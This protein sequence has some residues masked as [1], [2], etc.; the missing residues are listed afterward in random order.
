[1]PKL[2]EWLESYLNEMVNRKMV[3]FIET[4]NDSVYLFGGEKCRAQFSFTKSINSRN[5][6][7]LTFT[8]LSDESS[9]II[10]DEDFF[11]APP[12]TG[13]VCEP[14]TINLDGTDILIADSGSIVTINLE[15]TDEVQVIPDDVQVVGNNIKLVFPVAAPPAY[16]LDLVDRFGNAFP[17]KQVSANAT[18]DLR[19]LTPFDW[20]DIYLNTLTTPPSSLFEDAIIDL[21]DD[22]D[23][24]GLWGLK[25]CIWVLCEGTSFGTAL[26]LRY[27][28]ANKNSF[29]LSHI[30]SPTF[31][32]DGIQYNTTT[33]NSITFYNPE[34]GGIN[35]QHATI[36]S[37]TDSLLSVAAVDMGF[38]GPFT[39]IFIRD[40]NTN[41]SGYQLN[42][43]TNVGGSN[44]NSQ[45]NY[46]INLLSGTGKLVK[47]GSTT[48]ASG[49]VS[50]AENYGI[51]NIN[52]RDNQ[53]RTGRKYS[54]ASVGLGLTDTQIA[55]EYV[56][57]QTFHT[58]LGIQK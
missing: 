20:A 42:G 8:T 13:L 44:T 58:T 37:Q 25:R 18:W 43:S 4:F 29:Q 55:D 32:S 48:I 3:I 17:T 21:V 6:Y 36:Y 38:S 51:F 30:G 9:L 46:L 31:A 57:I 5:G 40:N 50:N 34:Y 56:A 28:F 23:A 22:L 54:F 11:P 45:G 10:N 24:S 19:T 39:G 14:V 47:N 53:F 33:N 12:D 7:E 52:G 35:N 15:D 26:N 41:R 2:N 1:V 27:P 49:S 16:D